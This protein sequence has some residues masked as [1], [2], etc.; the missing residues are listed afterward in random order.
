MRVQ[1]ILICFLQFLF[2]IFTSWIRY[3]FHTGPSAYLGVQ[4][5]SWLLLY[6][7]IM[8]FFFVCFGNKEVQIHIWCYQENE[9]FTWCRMQILIFLAALLRKLNSILS[10]MWIIAWELNNQ[11][12]L[13]ILD[14]YWSPCM[15]AGLGLW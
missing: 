1:N 12:P 6:L 13:Y 4:T 2:I 5:L 9:N 7:P 14:C 15:T 8:Y 3:D 11:E 10:N